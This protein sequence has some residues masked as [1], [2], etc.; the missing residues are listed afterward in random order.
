M[1][2]RTARD[3]AWRSAALSARSP[4]PATGVVRLWK[5]WLNLVE[6]FPRV[7]LESVL[8]VLQD[9]VARDPEGP[10]VPLIVCAVCH[11]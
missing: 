9:R 1:S 6:P 10:R 7:V 2:D 11:D 4:H 5:G 8:S 3:A